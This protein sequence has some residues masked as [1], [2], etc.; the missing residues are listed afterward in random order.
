MPEETTDDFNGWTPEQ[1][2]II[3]QQIIDNAMQ[4]R[5]SAASYVRTMSGWLIA[6]LFVGNAGAITLLHDSAGRE[7]LAIFLIGLILSVLTGLSAWFH[8]VKEFEINDHFADARALLGNR[9]FPVADAKTEKA[10][11]W[12][13]KGT[14]ILGGASGVCFVAGAIMALF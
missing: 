10:R 13:F 14:L 11:E 2:Q 12:G 3:T 5:E 4:D 9:H 1:W 7:T 6:Q 8:A